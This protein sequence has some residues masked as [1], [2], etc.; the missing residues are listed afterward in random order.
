MEFVILNKIHASQLLDF[1][2]E[3]KHWFESFIEPR[4]S[5]FY[6]ENGINEHIEYLINQMN[7]GKAYCG[8][9]IENNKIVARANL[10]DI[11]NQTAYVGYR[12]AKN[13]TSKGVASYCL[14][15]LLE[16]AKNKL[17]VK[18]LK[19]QVLE[20]NPASMHVLQKLGFQAL[21]TKANFL[22]LHN[23]KLSCI[24]YGLKYA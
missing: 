23:K 1:E 8:V 16:I 4:L 7:V 6:S 10:R 12:V 22:T 15:Q 9:L 18:Q 11:L 13:S 24:E 2:L 20:N 19:A 21:S 17:G 3:N 5:D 14:S